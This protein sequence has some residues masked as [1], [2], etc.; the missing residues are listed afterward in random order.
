MSAK[1]PMN[2][3]TI[4]HNPRCITSRNALALLRSKGV[5]PQV[6][7]YLKHP[8]GERELKRVIKLLGIPASGLLRRRE[9]LFKDLKLEGAGDGKAVAAMLEHPV[10]IERPVVIRSGRAVLARPPEKLLELL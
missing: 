3:W 8:P 10:L 9:R 2:E 4:F 1:N 7:D 6:V 5:E